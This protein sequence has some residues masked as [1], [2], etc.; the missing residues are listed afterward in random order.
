MTA[1][2]LPLTRVSAG[3]GTLLLPSDQAIA[4][5]V[6]AAFAPLGVNVATGT[7]YNFSIFLRLND[8]DLGGLR[9][10]FNGGT[11]V[12]SS[13]WATVV[14]FDMGFLSSQ[15]LSALNSVASFDGFAGGKGLVQ[16]D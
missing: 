12:V 2:L 13:F 6:L 1:G 16:I 10:D 15:Y 9:I 11:C 8:S 5:A 14:G 7:T 4:S 3:N